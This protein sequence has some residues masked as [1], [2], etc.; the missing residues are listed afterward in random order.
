MVVEKRTMWRKRASGG[1]R[2]LV[3]RVTGI[4]CLCALLL[5]AASARAV[6]P[7]EASDEARA[8]VAHALAALRVGLQLPSRQLVAGAR[9]TIEHAIAQYAPK[10]AWRVDEGTLA[11][12]V[13]AAKCPPQSVLMFSRVCVDLYENIVL[14]KVT[15]QTALPPD[16]R[17]DVA[18]E[19]LPASDSNDDGGAPSADSRRVA[20]GWL[21]HPPYLELEQGHVYMAV[22]QPLVVPQAYISGEQAGQACALA[23]KRLCSA[24]EWRLACGGSNGTAYPYGGARQPGYC[25]DAGR[26]VMMQL[27]ADKAARGFGF[28]ELNDPRINQELGTLAATGSFTQCV[29]DAGVFDMVGN[30]HE[31][32]ADPNGTFQGGYYLD[33]HEHGDGCAYRTIAHGAGYHDYSTGFRCCTNPAASIE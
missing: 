13:T 30:L 1:S 2:Q 32:T 15:A 14:E 11:P 20:L 5:L 8:Q 22:S 17:A 27:H 21:P 31:W 24:V 26:A 19:A 33:T 7:D 9:G 28:A 12:V 4:G 29:N 23:G 16:A 18:P 3:V 10:R 25:N 6:R